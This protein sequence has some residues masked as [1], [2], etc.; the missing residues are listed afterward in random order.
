MEN[1]NYGWVDST[2]SYPIPADMQAQYDKRMAEIRAAERR[3]YPDLRRPS[4]KD[5]GEES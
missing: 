1:R 4:D 5:R 3:K 2:P